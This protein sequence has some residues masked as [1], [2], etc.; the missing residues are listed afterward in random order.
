MSLITWNFDKNFIYVIIYW[1]LEIAYRVILYLRRNYFEITKNIVY[2]EYTF[3]ILYNISDLL[4]GFLVLYSKCV[5]KSKKIEKVEKRTESQSE[6]IC[7]KSNK[8]KKKFY[9]KLI[10][11][12]LLDYISRSMVWISYAITGAKNT[13][14]IFT[15]QKNI[16][17]TFDILMRYIFSVFILK[18]VIYK[19]RTFSLITIG[20]GFSIL[21]IN[22]IIFMSCDK[23]DKYDIPKTFI[24]TAIVSISSFTFPLKDT[25]EKKIFLE[26]Y[27]YPANLQFYRGIA[28]SI[29]TLVITL[30]LVFALGIDLE[31]ESTEF[32]IVIPTL[33]ICTLAAFFKAYITLKIIYHYSSQSV[34]FLLT[35]HSFGGSITKLIDIFKNELKNDEWKIA[36]FF[37]EIISILMILFASLV[38]DEIIIINKWRLNE[39]VKLGI[40]FRGEF[41]TKN[42]NFFRDSHFDGNQLFDNDSDSNERKSYDKENNE[43]NCNDAN[44][45]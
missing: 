7:T 2:Y 24:F 17:L 10:I 35:S 41:D 15:F 26:D 40:I 12:A 8:L 38:Y 34:S 31:F 4:A 30:I 6:L 5:S 25:F 32:S 45:E 29:L 20:I 33:I 23:S 11:V 42:M 22:D 28:E 27:L 18:I 21:I 19:H 37:L 44:N 14:I 3:L 16:A 43:E 1:I 39:N 36:L 13:Q 9:I